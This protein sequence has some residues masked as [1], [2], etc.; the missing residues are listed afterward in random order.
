[1]LSAAFS[2]AR[3]AKGMEEKTGFGLKNGLTLPSLA[4]KYFNSFRDENDEPIYTDNDKFM[5]HFVRES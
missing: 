2:Y 1:M 3:Y 4:D 5:R